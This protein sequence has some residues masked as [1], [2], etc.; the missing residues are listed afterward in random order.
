MRPE[1]TD[2]DE[3]RPIT[4]SKG[5]HLPSRSKSSTP[6]PTASTVISKHT[7]TDAA[8]TPGQTSASVP[9]QRD[10][11]TQNVFGRFAK[12]SNPQ[13]SIFAVPADSIP[14]TPAV[15]KRADPM[16]MNAFLAEPS[17]LTNAGNGS[18][19]PQTLAR[20]NSG[21]ASATT[22]SQGITLDQFAEITRVYSHACLRDGVVCLRSCKTCG[23]N[24]IRDVKPSDQGP[25][26]IRGEMGFLS[27][28]TAAHQDKGATKD[29]VNEFCTLESVSHDDAILMSKGLAPKISV[30]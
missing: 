25:H 2:L 23:Y 18:T 13:A 29:N 20:T 26:F 9:V 10:S 14:P 1:A 12:S 28:V 3:T 27:H 6:A 16:L 4:A 19:I 5:Q 15:R 21:R 24:A 22:P 30:I 7:E 11:G 8:S 17:E